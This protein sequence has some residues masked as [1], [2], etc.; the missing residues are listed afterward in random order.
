MHMKK[1]AISIIGAVFLAAAL[2]SACG[3][4]SYKDGVYT[5]RSG[6]D[7]LGAYGEATVTISGGE[8]SDCEYVTRQ[9]DGGIKDSEYGK[10]NGEISNQEYYDKAQFAV[11]A[12]ASYAESLKAKKNLKGVDAITGATIAYGQF[13]EAVGEALK[14]AEAK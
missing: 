14:Q 10:V 6:E 7:D 5:G 3:S 1:R 4:P 2:I 12:M 13:T 9:K 8:I 11:R